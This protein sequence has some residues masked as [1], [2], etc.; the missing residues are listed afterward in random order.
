MPLSGTMVAVALAS[1]AADFG[2]SLAETTWMV[3]LYLAITGALQ[4]LMGAIGDR[5]G[6][7][8]LYTAGIAGFGLASSLCAIAPTFG[9]LVV[10]RC[11]QA[12]T[13]AAIVPNGTSLLRDAVPEQAR[14][15]A[16]GIFGAVMGTAA[17][18]GLP[19]GAW[20]ASAYGWSLLF[21]VTVPISVVALIIALR[22]LPSPRAE[23]AS[24]SPIVLIGAAMLPL[25][26]GGGI[27]QRTGTGHRS[28]MFLLAGVAL[29]LVVVAIVASSKR[30]RRDVR[31][32]ATQP[33]WSACAV[34]AF[35]QLCFYVALLTLPTWLAT[36]LSVSRSSAGMYLG[37]L[38]VS[39]V[40]VVPTAGRVSDALGSRTLAL[41]GSAGVFGGLMMLAYVGDAPS[42]GQILAALVLM[43]S[44]V[45]VAFPALQR[46]ALNNAPP[47]SVAM[48]MG[49]FSNA[50]I[51]GAICG[52]LLVATQAGV[53]AAVDVPTGATTFFTTALVG[54]VPA[55]VAAM[56]LPGR[57]R[58]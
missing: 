52:T 57:A 20:L 5:L 43:G 16:L 7:R 46:A 40:I 18:V 29:S 31:T 55:V 4:P 15:R 21:W 26:I 41:T 27:A 47:G 12:A 13:S 39:A 22:Q 38:A 6:R 42:Q 56:F 45:G 33:F 48:A 34:M 36:A 35:I 8:K 1:I 17:S 23:P 2:I 3:T 24:L 44:G 37:A 30:G 28:N 49:V 11:F 25:A 51:L 58:A 32:L 14:G 53:D 10:A 9:V 19:L 50:R 54:A